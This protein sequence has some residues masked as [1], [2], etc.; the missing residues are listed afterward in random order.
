MHQNLLKRKNKMTPR[1]IIRQL[2]ID[3]D[4]FKEKNHAGEW[5]HMLSIKVLEETLQKIID[6]SEHKISNERIGQMSNILENSEK[7][8]HEA[9]SKLE[10]LYYQPEK[11]VIVEQQEWEMAGHNSVDSIEVTRYYEID[12]CGQKRRLNPKEEIAYLKWKN[13][14]GKNGK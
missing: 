12:D 9:R 4:A 1:D 13:Q 14:K 2:I 6:R 7:Q 11:R 5:I 8:S 3:N 10:S